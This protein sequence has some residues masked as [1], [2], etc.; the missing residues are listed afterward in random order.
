MSSPDAPLPP[1]LK[2]A[3][4]AFKKRLKLTMLDDESR[5]GHGAM[6]GGRHSGVRAIRPPDQFP[7]AVW[8]ELVKLGKIKRVGHGLYELLSP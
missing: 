7:Q 3:L 6:T 1:E 4:K 5:L 8:D 2:S